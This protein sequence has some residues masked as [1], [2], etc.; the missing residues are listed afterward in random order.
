M[1]SLDNLYHISYILFS[2]SSEKESAGRS[3]SADSKQL[4]REA[5]K[6]RDSELPSVAE[7]KVETVEVTT[8]DSDKDQRKCDYKF[9]FVLQTIG[10]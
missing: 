9:R 2:E 3:I 6:S 5:D 10:Q 8:T 1:P 7:G 4:L